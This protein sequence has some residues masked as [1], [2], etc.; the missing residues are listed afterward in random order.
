MNIRKTNLATVLATPSDKPTDGTFKYKENLKITHILELISYFDEL[1]NKVDGLFA[2]QF[3][4][5]DLYAFINSFMYGRI[6]K[7]NSL[8]E[9]VTAIE[10]CNVGCEKDAASCDAK[11][12]KMSL[13]SFK[14]TLSELTYERKPVS[15]YLILNN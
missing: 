15:T 9:S 1:I 11:Q 5:N 13:N 14:K 6:T 7:L 3:K 12:C 4:D 8:I 10:S 2:N